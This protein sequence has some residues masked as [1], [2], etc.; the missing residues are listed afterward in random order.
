MKKNIKLI[1]ALGFISL[2]GAVS[3]QK[4]RIDSLVIRN[5]SQG[6]N[7]VL[8]SDSLGN[9]TWATPAVSSSQNIYNTDGTLTGNRVVTQGAN[10]LNFT[11]TGTTTFN[12][13]NV[14]VGA[15]TP[16][17]KLHVVG[18]GRIDTMPTAAATDSIVTRLSISNGELRQMSIAR[19]LG[20]L[21]TDGDGIVDANDPDIDGDGVLNANDNCRLQYG[22]EPTGCPAS[23]TV[24]AK[25]S[26]FNSGTQTSPNV[27][28]LG[29]KT[30]FPSSAN[31]VY[32]IDIDSTGN[33]FNPMQAQCDM[34]TDGG[35]WTLIM[36][37]LHQGGT[38]SLTVARTTL[39]IINSS[40]LGTDESGN[41]TSW[42]HISNFMASAMTF[43]T[44]RFFG[45]E[46]GHSRVL[47]FKTT[48]GISYLKTGTGSFNG[49][50]TNFTGLAAHTANLPACAN[51]FQTNAGNNALLNWPFANSLS[52]CGGADYNIQNNSSWA[53]D[54]QDNNST[55]TLH[56]VWVR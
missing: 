23:C 10:T 45:I 41:A 49:V 28:C 43:T 18:R 16:T 37:Y 29:I 25:P 24:N 50:V 2:C 4:Q 22:C 19:L 53:V 56:R 51:F 39:P 44:I 21:D 27:S 5:G 8:V 46:T 38:N 48:T 32:W 15:T 26:W 30:N 35:G 55:N 34:T 6:L 17:H 1:F 3:A 33:T 11:G 14:G 12:S 40:S 42:G 20:Q 54:T 7:K 52:G 36:N 13:G 9:A 31:G 47:D